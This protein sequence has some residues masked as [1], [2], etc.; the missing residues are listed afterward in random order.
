MGDD[1]NASDAGGNLAG[2][3]SVLTEIAQ[4]SVAQMGAENFPVAL[5]MLPREPRDSLSRVYAFAR[6]V[7]DVGDEAPGDRYALLDAVARQV[8]AQ[9]DGAEAALAPVRGLGPLIT[10]H[11]MPAQPFLDLIEANRID[12]KISEYATF[13]DLIG[14]CNYSAAP[15]GRIV[16]RL[17]EAD[18]PS[19]VAASDEVCN[20]LQVLE[21]CQ[22]VGED[23]ARGRIYL[24]QDDL[25]RAGVGSGDLL[26]T[27]T[28]TSLR[29]VIA[30]QVDR[31]E[32]MLGAGRGLV[33]SLRGWSRFAVAGYLAGGEATARAL[34]RADYDVLPATIR[35]AK[36][37]VALALARRVVGK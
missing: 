11:A 23:A 30:I 32:R 27:S 35:P 28:S 3:P 26:A 5:R 16:L 6:F 36:A 7:D 21:H 2:L 29:R 18:T 24:P 12:Q 20:A 17:A 31:A 13:A 22:D 10:S 25:R 33:R 14:Y 8:Q 34:A 9:W 4:R 15:V 19:N 37:Q 1:S